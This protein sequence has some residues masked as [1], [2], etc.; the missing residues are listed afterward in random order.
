MVEGLPLVEAA[1]LDRPF[2]RLARPAECETAGLSRNGD[3]AAIEPG[4]VPVDLDPARRRLALAS[5]E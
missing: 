4:A 5:V 3:D 1:H 2:D